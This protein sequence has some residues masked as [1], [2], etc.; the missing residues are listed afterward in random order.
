MAETVGFAM[1]LT[2]E[3]GVLTMSE[4]STVSTKKCTKCKEV[5]KRADFSNSAANRDALH[6]WCKECA[7]LYRIKNKKS[8]SDRNIRYR[9]ENREDVLAR[10]AYYRNKNREAVLVSNA[11]YR[12]SNKGKINSWTAKRRAQKLQATPKWLTKEQLLEI[13]AFYIEAVRLTRETGKPHHVDHILPILGDGIT[14]LHV[15]WNLQILTASENSKKRNKF[16]FTYEN[17]SWNKQ[18]PPS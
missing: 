8:I 11:L 3:I 17:V 4:N 10:D 15:P 6:C 2:E 18:K 16:D 12:G 14:G 7:H 13:L 9:S 1:K 5:K